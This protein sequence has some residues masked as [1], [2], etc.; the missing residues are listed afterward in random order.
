MVDVQQTDAQEYSLDRCTASPSRPTATSL[1][2]EAQDLSALMNRIAL[3][4]KIIARRLS[5]GLMEGVL[6]LPETL[7]CRRIRQKM[8]VYANDVLSRYSSKVDLSVA[9]FRGN[10][11]PYYIPENFLLVA[12]PCFMTRLT[13]PQTP[14]L[15]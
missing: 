7:M 8:D 13:A 1:L 5:A 11:K 14:I 3:A 6:G 10:G 2:A 12:I 4:G 9:C 15:I